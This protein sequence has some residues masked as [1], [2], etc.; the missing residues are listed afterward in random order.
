MKSLKLFFAVFFLSF[1]N[2]TDLKA[3]KS[4][5]FK[6]TNKTKL[7]LSNGDTLAN[8]FAGGLNNP[9]IFNIDINGDNQID[10]LVFD[11]DGSRWI[12]FEWNL[13]H[14]KYVPQWIKLFPSCQIG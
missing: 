14:W 6:P 8:G 13:N 10:L 3:Q 5:D 2:L 11:R 1:F 4:Y 9:Q 12:P 7:I